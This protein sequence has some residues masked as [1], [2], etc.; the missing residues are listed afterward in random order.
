MPFIDP[1]KP[2]LLAYC[3][4][5]SFSNQKKH[6]VFLRCE[7]RKERKKKS[8]NK[9]DVIVTSHRFLCPFCEKHKAWFGGAKREKEKEKRDRKRERRKRKGF[10]RIHESPYFSF[11]LPFSF[12][13][14]SPFPFPYPFPFSLSLPFS[15]CLCL[16]PFTLIGSNALSNHLVR[17]AS[18]TRGEMVFFLSFFLCTIQLT[19]LEKKKNESKGMSYLQ[20]RVWSSWN[21]VM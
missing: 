10:A 4:L 7:G 11:T 16:F 1:K 19:C 14:L 12:S 2:S 15:L 18:N 5:F 9:R 17:K 20:W 21:T 6:L 3:F 13:L 8:Q